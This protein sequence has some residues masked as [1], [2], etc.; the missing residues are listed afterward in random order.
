RSSLILACHELPEYSDQSFG[1]ISLRGSA[2]ARGADPQTD[3]ISRLLQAHLGSEEWERFVVQHK[4]KCGV[5]PAFQGDERDVVFISVVD[6]PSDQ[7][8]GG[9]LRLVSE[10]S[11]PGLQYKK[12]LNVAV[13]RARNQVWIAHSFDHFESQLRDDDIRRRLME[14]AYA[15]EEWLESTRAENPEAESPFEQSVYADLVRLG[16]SV[17]PQVPVGNHR[18]DLVV[19]NRDARVALECDGDAYHQ[20]AAADLA[21]QLV[22]ERCGWK[23]V[24]IR[25]SEYYRDAQKAIMRV[26]RDLEKL[27]VTP[28]SFRAASVEP[29]GDL[30]AAIHNRAKEVRALLES[31]ESYRP[32][33][34]SSSQPVR[35]TIEPCAPFDDS[36]LSDWVDDESRDEGSEDSFVA[37]TFVPVDCN[38][39]ACTN[40]TF[41]E[42]ATTTPPVVVTPSH[43]KPAKPLSGQPGHRDRVRVF[44]ANG[45]TVVDAGTVLERREL[46]GSVQW[47]ILPDGT[48]TARKFL[49]PPARIVRLDEER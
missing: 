16:F 31:G 47:T 43:R 2:D 28:T 23:F 17:T 39:S 30:L 9:P 34:V 27:G 45:N 33:F 20:D 41:E 35:P 24:R 26:V 22:L 21:R 5:P 40:G 11:M 37:G 32:C 25:G 44:S 6:A 13:S 12:R 3:R 48:S 46:A 42:T 10:G 7:G 1:V 29:A 19:E 8:N 14:F 15:P 18:I 38:G 36:E 4:F 49:S